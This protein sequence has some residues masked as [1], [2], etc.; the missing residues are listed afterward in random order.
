MLGNSFAPFNWYIRDSPLQITCSSTRTRNRS[1]KHG[2]LQNN[3]KKQRTARREAHRDLVKRR[4][5]VASAPISSREQIT[6][7]AGQRTARPSDGVTPC[8][9][10]T[11]P[12]PRRRHYLGMQM[13]PHH[14]FP[15]TLRC[16][17]IFMAIRQ[18][19]HSGRRRGLPCT[20]K[21]ERNWF[22]KA[23]PCRFDLAPRVRSLPPPPP[24]LH[25]RCPS[26]ERTLPALHTCPLA[27]SAARLPTFLPAPAESCFS[28]KR[29]GATP[30]GH[31]RDRLALSAKGAFTSFVSQWQ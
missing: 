22:L 17:C 20:S 8:R 12:S 5:P 1:H 10:C 18:V 16:C 27:R 13:S 24:S 28:R 6:L 2:D 25:L 30:L 7:R 31:V 14:G 29:R 11:W 9:A 15:R 21:R 3:K 26:R 23:G 19:I 4:L